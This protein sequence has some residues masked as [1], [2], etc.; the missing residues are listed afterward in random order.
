MNLNYYIKVRTR[1]KFLKK[2]RIPDILESID[3]PNESQIEIKMNILTNVYN[4]LC[5]SLSSKWIK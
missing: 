1:Y 3:M 4:G 5:G 2:N